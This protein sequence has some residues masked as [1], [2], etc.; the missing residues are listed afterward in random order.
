MQIGNI[1]FAQ[2][3]LSL[4]PLAGYGDIAFRR[5]CR[6]SGASLTVTEMVSAKGLIYGNEKTETLLRL[7]PCE[8]PSCVQ[9]FGSDPDCFYKAVSLPA[10]ARF[11]IIDINMGCP[12]PKITKCGEG[13][14]LMRDVNRA[15]DIVRACVSAA[16]GR[17]VT[18]KHRLGWDSDRIVAPDFAAKMQSAGAAAITVHG[19]TAAQGYGGTA[20]WNT[21]SDVARAVSVPVIGNGDIRSRADANEKIETFGVAGAAIVRGSVVIPLVFSENG[22]E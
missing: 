11:D 17:P 14:A 13:S 21:I 2:P 5:L 3:F 15:A 4:A 22:T 12:V 8:R 20:D 9:L 10:L 7:A 19:R 16:N 18:V 6:E 1:T